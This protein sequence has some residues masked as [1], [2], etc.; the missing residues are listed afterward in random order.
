MPSCSTSVKP[1]RFS[2]GPSSSPASTALATLPTPDWSGSMLLGRRPSFTSC[3]RKVDDVRRDL[4]V[5]ASGAANTLSRSPLVR[6]HHGDHLVWVHAQVGLA[7]A[8]YRLRQ[9]GWAGAAAEWPCRSR[10]RAC[11]PSRGGRLLTSRI[12]LSAISSQVLLLP[13]AA[14]DQAPSGKMPATSTTATSCGPESR[15]RPAAPRAT[16]GCPGNAAR[17]R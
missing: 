7:D 12:T 14:G 16:G 2:N 9:A 6:F 15:T 13:T 17:R 3:A 5:T 11:P 8:L 1:S 10:C 4:L